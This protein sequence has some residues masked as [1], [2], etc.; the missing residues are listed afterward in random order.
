MRAAGT[1]GNQIDIALAH[2]RAFFGERQAPMR[3]LAFRK[4]VIVPGMPLAFKERN[5]RVC[6]KCL[7]QVIAQAALVLPGLGLA[8]LLGM[9]RYGHAGHQ[10]RLAAQKMRQIG[11]RHQAGLE[12]FA[13]GPDPH[14]GALPPV[15]FGR[16]AHL[17]LLCHVA[18]LEHHPG[19][20]A[21]A[22]RGC[23][24]PL[25]QCVGDGD[26][27][28]VQ[29]AREVVG[30]ALALVEFAAGMQPGENQLDDRCFFFRVQAERNAASVVLY[31]DRAIG[32]QRH[33]DPLAI[34]AQ[35]FVGSVVD[36]FLDDMQRVVGAG[37][38]ARPGLHRLQ[39]LEHTDRGF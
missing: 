5:H 28:A 27:D 26:A 25:G 33:L 39:A 34:A 19:D 23:L 16:L 14:G 30:A 24:Q 36:D 13:I 22:V 31:A 4:I 29:P 21:L 32:V 35:G 9:Q 8:G 18:G 37:V 7:H 3:A 38:H 11:H 17:Q 20:L 15:A 10:H 2:Q 1:R 6:A 12:V